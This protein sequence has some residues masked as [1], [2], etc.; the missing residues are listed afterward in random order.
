[1]ECF[2]LSPQWSSSGGYSGEPWR[3]SS[4]PT[5]GSHYPSRTRHTIRQSAPFSNVHQRAMT[6]ACV[7]AGDPVREFLFVVQQ[8]RSQHGDRSTPR[9]AGEAREDDA[10]AALNAL[11]PDVSSAN[12]GSRCCSETLLRQLDPSRA[13]DPSKPRRFDPRAK[14]GS[15]L[16]AARSRT[17]RCSPTQRCSRP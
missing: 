16:P 7:R 3:Q 13:P 5:Y 8:R 12:G 2:Y 9:A 14:S 10:A 4:T 6:V 1:V 11:W 17:P 15:H